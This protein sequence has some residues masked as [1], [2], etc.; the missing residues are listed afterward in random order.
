MSQSTKAETPAGKAPPRLYED[1]PQT[2]PSLALDAALINIGKAASWLW[3]VVVAIIIWAVTRRYLF[4][5]TSIAMDEMQWHL[6]GSAWLLGLSYTLAVDEHVRVD[7]LHERMRMRTQCWIEFFGLLLLL[8]PFL[9]IALREAVPFALDA[10]RNGE[11]SVAPGGL[12]HRWLVKS[13]LSV[14][15]SLLI[16]A[17]LSRLLRVTAAL[18]GWPRPVPAR[19]RSDR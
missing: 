15:L 6:V 16:I 1:L 7:V 3:L 13:V 11:R 4:G 2:S 12:A 9:V 18:F 10:Y 8:L 14:S 5:T 19:K 17:A